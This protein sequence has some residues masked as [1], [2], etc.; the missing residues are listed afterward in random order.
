[1]LASEEDETDFQKLSSN[2]SDKV[3][4]YLNVSIAID[5]NMCLVIWFS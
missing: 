3:K 5:N 4:L 2:L 1:M